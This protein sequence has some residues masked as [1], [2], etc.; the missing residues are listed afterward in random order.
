MYRYDRESGL[1]AAAALQP[2][3]LR[4]FEDICDLLDFETLAAVA[5]VYAPP[6]AAG[7]A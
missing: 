5:N 7:E 6:I 1:A 2:F 4:W 3:G